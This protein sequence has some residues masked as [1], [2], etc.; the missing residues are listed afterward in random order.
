MCDI[1]YLVYVSRVKNKLIQHPGSNP[2]QAMSERCFI[3]HSAHLAYLVH[4]MAV[5]QQHLH[6]KT[7]W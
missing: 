6:L 5:E 2:S 4:K 7:K 3:F 1:K